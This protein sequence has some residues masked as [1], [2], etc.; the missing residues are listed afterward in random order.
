L[1]REKPQALGQRFLDKP[2][3]EGSR[4]FGVNRETT[5]KSAKSETWEKPWDRIASQ[6]SR[7]FAWFR[8]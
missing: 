6:I 1:A 3:I 4:E 2:E 7:S 5:R 8:G